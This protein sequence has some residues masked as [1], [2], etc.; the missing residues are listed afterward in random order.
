MQVSSESVIV[1]VFA[2]R[3]SCL[4]YTRSPREKLWAIKATDSDSTA[5]WCYGLL[6]YCSLCQSAQEGFPQVYASH[7]F[8]LQTQCSHNLFQWWYFY[9]IG[10]ILLLS[11]VDISTH[12][13]Y[14][15]LAT[16]RW[17]SKYKNWMCAC[18]L[19]RPVPIFCCLFLHNF[20][21]AS[22]NIGILKL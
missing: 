6:Q 1:T 19:A 20:F 8:Q 14:V 22:L 17:Q 10:V 12:D 11:S 7:F 5:S 13:L 9:T 4:T 15:E 21:K 18:P 2:I 3:V 16:G